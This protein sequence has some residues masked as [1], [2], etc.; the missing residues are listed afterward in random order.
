[1]LY[2]VCTGL[3]YYFESFP[4]SKDNP[5]DVDIVNRLYKY[6]KELS[7]ISKDHRFGNRGLRDVYISFDPTK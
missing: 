5:G 7:A 3:T 2:G 4:L 6:I 1:M